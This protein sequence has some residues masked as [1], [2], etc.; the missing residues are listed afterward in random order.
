VVTG[1]DSGIGTAVAIAY[2]RAGA[3]VLVSQE[4]THAQALDEPEHF[5]R[6]VAGFHA[7]AQVPR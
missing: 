4:T 1:A 6:V 5:D 2:A 3:D 7:D